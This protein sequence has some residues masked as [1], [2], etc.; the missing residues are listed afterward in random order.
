MVNATRSA[1]PRA[2]SH[3]DKVGVTITKHGLAAIPPFP[4]ADITAIRYA[5]I[6]VLIISPCIERKDINQEV[7]MD[8]SLREQFVP[9]KKTAKS[10]KNVIGI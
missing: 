4:P 8:F 3:T 5:K 2:A 6:A 10:R 1:S 9:V 7:A